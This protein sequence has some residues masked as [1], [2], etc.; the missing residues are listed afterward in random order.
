MSGV[1]DM[2]RFMDG[3]YDDNF[4][5]NNPVDYLVESLRRLVLPPDTT[6]ATSTS[7]PGPGPWETA[8]TVVPLVVRFSARK[9]IPHSLDDWG[10]LGGHDWPYWHHMMW[11]YVSKLY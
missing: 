9:G 5:F 1:Y 2:T 11:E 10:P 3:M 8:G 6:S 7:S 4:Y